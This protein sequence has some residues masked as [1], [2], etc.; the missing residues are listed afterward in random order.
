MLD[1]ETL[2]KE[3]NRCYPVDKRL[4]GKIECKGHCGSEIV[5]EKIQQL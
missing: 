2:N 4:C 5:E 1:R 3:L